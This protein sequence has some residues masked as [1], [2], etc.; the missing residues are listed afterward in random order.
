MEERLQKL[1]AQAGIASRRAAEEMIKDGEVLVNGNVAV[2]GTKADPE[3]D[4][5]K[6]R[7]KLINARLEKYEK[8]YLLLNK[9]TGYITSKAD[10]EG[11]QLVTELVGKYRDKVHPVGRLDVNSEGL[12]LLTNDGQFTQAV[13]HAAG[14]VAK[15][16][17]VKV[18]GQPSERQ[19]RQIAR[20]VELDGVKT[21]RAEINPIELSETNAWFEV[22]LYEGRNQQIRK[23]FK[24]IGHSVLKL[25]RVAIGFLKIERLATGE[26]RALTDAEVKRFFKMKESAPAKPLP[27][28]VPNLAEK[29]PARKGPPPARARKTKV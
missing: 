2:L 24:S 23:M 28:R 29:R 7:G 22:T 6:V 5:I 1:I 21:A 8:V 20:G 18:K 19:I 17:H 26:V 4:H 27:R 16:Y 10:P 3:K 13:A 9:P 11:R 15:V 14:K 12:L 25:K